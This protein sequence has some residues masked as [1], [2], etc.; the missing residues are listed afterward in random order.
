MQLRAYFCR[1]SA[2]EFRPFLAIVFRKEL[3][4]DADPLDLVS[5][6]EFGL[7]VRCPRCRSGVGRPCRMGRS[8]PRWRV[9]HPAR[10]YR[11]LAAQRKALA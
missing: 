7:D 10:T 6:L 3:T 11:A 2:G 5:A 1:N 8:A 9:A 4:V